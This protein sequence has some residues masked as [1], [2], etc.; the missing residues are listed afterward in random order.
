[1]RVTGLR[2]GRISAEMPRRIFSVM[3]ARYPST[4]V[5]SYQICPK[6][7]LLGTPGSAF[8]GGPVTCDKHCLTWPMA[9]AA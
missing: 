5:A 6:R 7:V 1:M 8:N 4:L 3:P 2:Y 9:Q